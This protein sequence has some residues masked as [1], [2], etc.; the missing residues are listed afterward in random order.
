MMINRTTKFM[1]YRQSLQT[2]PERAPRFIRRD[3]APGKGADIVDISEAARMKML[4]KN[5]TPLVK[6]I[7]SFSREI[8]EM[9]RT[10]ESEA[11]A[12]RQDRIEELRARI[13]GGSY[14]F[15]S[16]EKLESAAASLMTRMNTRHNGP[17]CA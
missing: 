14:N 9:V 17:E 4:E 5:N 16:A 15:D 12:R 7:M 13:R 1:N 3:S 2:G 8:G 6:S 11:D 10:A